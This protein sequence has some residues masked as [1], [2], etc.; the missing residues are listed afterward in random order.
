MALLTWARIHDVPR[1][2]AIV[3][4]VSRTTLEEVLGIW[5]EGDA[6]LP[7]DPRMPTEMQLQLAREM[8]AS[9]IRSE[10][11]HFLLEQ[12]AP[13]EPGDALVMA[14][15]GTTGAPKG[16]VLTHQALTAS[17]RITTEALA[18]GPG[19]KW[20]ACLP[21]AH[22]GGFSVLTRALLTNTA[23]QV[24]EGGFSAQGVEDAAR[25]GATHV[26]LVATAMKR[27]NTTLFER[28][29]LGGGP[30]PATCP[31]NAVATYGSTETASGIVYDGKALPE[32]NMR[33]DADGRLF[34]KSPTLLRCYR[35]GTEPFTPDGWFVTNDAATISADGTLDV[36]GRLDDAIITGGE[37]VWPAAV[38]SALQ[39]L[40]G[41]TAAFVFGEAD[42]EWGERVVAQIEGNPQSR[43]LLA[44]L[45]RQR[46][47]AYAI[48]KRWEFVAALDRTPLGKV[49]RRRP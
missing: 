10:D 32:V 38:E 14:T 2:V 19:H 20:L 31:P 16:V 30:R 11:T 34:V 40:P 15:S 47:P 42:P 6:V 27:I 17:A 45:V 33:V 9:E 44:E 41:V 25:N 1:L 48:P 13:V 43:Q 46:L 8:G 5:D 4:P 3:A 22:I 49:R 12:S 39:D 18:I 24:L 37:K 35:D 7:L 21:L 28:I 23:L 29:L 26:S 36:L